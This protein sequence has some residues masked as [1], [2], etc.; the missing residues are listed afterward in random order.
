MAGVIVQGIYKG[1]ESY[2][3]QSSPFCYAYH[4]YGN[5]PFSANE[6]RYEYTAGFK[7][8]P[9][10]E[11]DGGVKKWIEDM[12]ADIIG[13]Q[14]PCTPLIFVKDDM[15]DQFFKERAAREIEINQLGPMARDMVFN[16]K[17]SECTPGWGNAKPC[18]FRRL[19]H[20]EQDVNPLEKGY[21]WRAPHHIP[22]MDLWKEQGK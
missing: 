3:K 13:E 12:P 22:E 11:L 5:P 21:A 9:T 7:R 10:W 16:H 17:F 2:G 6:T 18:S 8:Y 15:V 1:Y 19:C 20:G 4:R 14:F